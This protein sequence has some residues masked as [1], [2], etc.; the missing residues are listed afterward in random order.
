[1]RTLS[2]AMAALSQHARA[3]LVPVLKLTL[4]R[5][6]FGDSPT[7][8]V[9]WLSTRP[10]TVTGAGEIWPLLESVGSLAE[11]S[12]ELTPE[13]TPGLLDVV[14][15]NDVPLDVHGVA[16][17]TDLF[18]K[19]RQG[20]GYDAPLA[21][22]VLYWVDTR[23]LTL[24]DAVV[25][26]PFLVDQPQPVT[27]T[28]V[29]L[30]LFTR[31]AQLD[32]RREALTPAFVAPAEPPA[33]AF[34]TYLHMAS[35]FEAVDSDLEAVQVL[36]YTGIPEPF[37]MIHERYLV[38]V[39]GRFL[40]GGVYYPQGSTFTRLMACVRNL[41]ALPG[42]TLRLVIAS[43]G[44]GLQ[45]GGGIDLSEESLTPTIIDTV[46]LH[47]YTCDTPAT[48]AEME[49]WRPYAN[50]PAG[51]VEVAA[52]TTSGTHDVAIGA[53]AAVAFLVEPAPA[54]PDAHLLIAFANCLLSFEP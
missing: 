39:C 8:L 9:L 41:T 47:V 12:A 6:Q 4:Y 11:A 18:R 54:G 50:F 22:A 38:G 3:E 15:A 24:T 21:R 29:G 28:R 45:R 34:V 36:D 35:M 17:F 23:A 33:E 27:R 31:D 30:R 52:I 32:V 19:G 26:G 37:S 13:V 10:V 14:V 25:F 48:L 20:T 40:T 49:A 5:D 7:S 16:R 53:A 51:A 46:T 43:G 44:I 2:A 1:M 42:T